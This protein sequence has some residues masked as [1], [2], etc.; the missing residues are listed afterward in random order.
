MLLAFKTIQEQQEK[1]E[2]LLSREQFISKIA[3]VFEGHILSE[4]ELKPFLVGIH[5][6][7]V[8]PQCFHPVHNPIDLKVQG[9]THT[10][11]YKC[12]NCQSE[13]W[14]QTSIQ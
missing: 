8:C 5:S 14:K 9:K 6:T 1:K 12:V 3:A 13:F 10:T 2:K 7:A 4:K 11:L